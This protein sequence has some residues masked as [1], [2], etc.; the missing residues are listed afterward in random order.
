MTSRLEHRLSVDVPN[1]GNRNPDAYLYAAEVCGVEPAAM[2][3]AAVH[4]SG[5]STAHTG[6][7]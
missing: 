7:D 6:R 3:L 5:T 2:A 1:G 4:P